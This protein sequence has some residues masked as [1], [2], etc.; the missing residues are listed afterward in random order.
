MQDTIT[1]LYCVCADL[2]QALG[3]DDDPQM[4]LS[5]AEIMMMPLVGALYERR[6]ECPAACGGALWAQQRSCWG[7]GSR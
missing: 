2:L 6:P 3:I 5:E 4:R 7:E 1:T